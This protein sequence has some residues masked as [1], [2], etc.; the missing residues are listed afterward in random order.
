MINLDVPSIGKTPHGKGPRT[1]RQARKARQRRLEAER[2][3]RRP[4]GMDTMN[5]SGT[6]A[7]AHAPGGPVDRQ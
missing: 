5:L 2:L 4:A 7:S 1:K 6:L 3:D